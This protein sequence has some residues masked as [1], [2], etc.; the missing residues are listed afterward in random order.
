MEKKAE[1]VKTIK[2]IAAK[3][4]YIS[5]IIIIFAVRTNKYLLIWKI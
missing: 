4:I 2:C 5:E 3:I 1:K